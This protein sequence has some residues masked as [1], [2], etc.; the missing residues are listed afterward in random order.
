MPNLEESLLVHPWHGIQNTHRNISVKTTSNYPH[1]FELAKC[2]FSTLLAPLLRFRET[3]PQV[4]SICGVCPW[5][6]I[7][8]FHF[9]RSEIELSR[10]RNFR[11][12]LF[13]QATEKGKRCN[14]GTHNFVHNMHPSGHRVR[15]SRFLQFASKLPV[16]RAGCFREARYENYLPV[17][18]L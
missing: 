11:K 9:Q 1:I 6:L 18:H 14:Q 3:C 10:V 8:S 7:T 4:I 16:R 17:C 2:S 12:V 13:P 5:E 15:F